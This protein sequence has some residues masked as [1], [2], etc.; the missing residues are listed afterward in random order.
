MSKETDVEIAK[1]TKNEI[2]L[3]A[4]DRAVLGGKM[5]IEAAK[6]AYDLYHD[7]LVVD[8]DTLQITL[9]NRPLDEAL[10]RICEAR[11]LWKPQGPDARV[12]AR[13]ALEAEVLAGSVSGHGRA[14]KEWGREAYEAFCAKHASKP[15]KAAAGEKDKDDKKDERKNP[16]LA[17]QWSLAAQGKLVREIGLAAAQSIAKSAGSFVGATKPS[18]AA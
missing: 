15:G 17:D 1:A 14:F 11:P 16:W 2:L 6:D 12:V 3:Q 5:R 8:V 18:R 13:Q 9:E 7:K 10:D 4:I